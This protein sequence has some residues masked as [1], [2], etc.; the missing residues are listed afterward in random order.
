[1]KKTLILLAVFSLKVDASHPYAEKIADAI[2]RVEG[3]ANTRYPYGVKG[4]FTIPPRQVCLNTIN[5]NYTRYLTSGQ[6]PYIGFL[7]YLAQ[8]YCPSSVDPVGH[9]NWSKNV[10]SIM[11]GKNNE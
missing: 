2:Y 7:D 11:K 10:R 6:A 1:M 9:V 3:G 5:N 8:R 4:I